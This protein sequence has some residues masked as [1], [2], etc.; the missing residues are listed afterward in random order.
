MSSLANWSYTAQA[1]VWRRL[2][3]NEYG[4]SLGWSEPLVIACDY[5]GGLSKRLGAIGV[6]KVVKNT[7]WTEYALATTGDYILI[8]ASAEPDP[9]AAGAD[10]IMQSIQYA[11]TFERTADDWAIITG[12]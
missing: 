4:D 5:Q 9:I 12:V 2:G 7:I 10:E 11:D 1:T 3:L 8:G 6:E